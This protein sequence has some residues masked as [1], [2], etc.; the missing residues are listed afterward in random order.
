MCMTLARA[1]LAYRYRSEYLLALAADSIIRFSTS[2]KKSGVAQLHY[3][4]LS[5]CL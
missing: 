5:R 2:I 3:R 1:L 4:T